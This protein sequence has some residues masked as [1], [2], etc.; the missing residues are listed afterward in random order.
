MY[1]PALLSHATSMSRWK[2]CSAI[3]STVLDAL[4]DDMPYFTPSSILCDD[5]GIKT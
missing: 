3:A 2:R 5:A 4:F 1:G